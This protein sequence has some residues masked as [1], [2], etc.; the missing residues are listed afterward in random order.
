[1]SSQTFQSAVLAVMTDGPREAAAVE[2]ILRSQGATSWEPRVVAQLLEFS[3]RHTGEVLH[4]A[5]QYAA[6]RTSR[7]AFGSAPLTVDDVR[8][9]AQCNSTHTFTE[10]LGGD[11][12]ARMAQLLN[13]TPLP[14]VPRRQGLVYPAEVALLAPTFQV[15]VRTHVTLASLRCLLSAL[16]HRCRVGATAAKGPV[17]DTAKR[18]GARSSG[19][20]TAGHSASG[21]IS[22]AGEAPEAAPCRRTV[23]ATRRGWRCVGAVSWSYKK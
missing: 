7:E 9:A 11:E 17:A 16:T 3:Y 6:H 12:L 22:Q 4:E 21:Q 15:C 20:G 10:P 13:S 8:L 2:A 18:C 14:P 1:M 5:Q 19:G 23:S